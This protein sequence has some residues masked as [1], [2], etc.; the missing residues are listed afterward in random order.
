MEYHTLYQYL[1]FIKKQQLAFDDLPREVRWCQHGPS[2]LYSFRRIK[3]L[4]R[5]IQRTEY[6]SVQHAAK[7]VEIE[8][9]AIKERVCSC[10]LT[11]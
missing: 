7:E 5:L 6:A 1:Q 10:I 8:L 4:A 9:S 3:Q 2:V 11:Q